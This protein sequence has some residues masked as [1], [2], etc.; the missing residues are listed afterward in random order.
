MYVRHIRFAKFTLLEVLIVVAIMLIA[1]TLIT[2]QL[3]KLP[4][5]VRTKELAAKVSGLYNYASELSESYNRPMVLAYSEVQKRFFIATPAAID[6]ENYGENFMDE[7][8][9]IHEPKEFKIDEFKP[10]IRGREVIIPDKVEVIIAPESPSVEQILKLDNLDA[11]EPIKTAEYIHLAILY[12]D[13]SAQA[14][15][16]QLKRG[17]QILYVQINPWNSSLIISEEP[18]EK[19]EFNNETE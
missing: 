2:T 10:Y 12:P 14:R 9:L 19:D 3:A 17:A 6:E 11:N 13:G 4:M 1:S 8:T 18:F 7:T 15:D 16:C 5:F